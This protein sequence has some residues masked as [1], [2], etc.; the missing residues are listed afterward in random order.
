MLAELWGR[1]RSRTPPWIIVPDVI[2]A[3]AAALLRERVSPRLAPFHIPNRGR[4]AFAD[5]GGEGELVAE[6]VQLCEHLAQTE[7]TLIGARLHRLRQGDYAL[8][9]DDVCTRVERG[10]HL[11][12]TLDFSAAEISCAEV[13]YGDGRESALVIP[14][15]PGSMALV[16]RE[17]LVR[18]TA[19]EVL[20]YDRYLTHPVGAREVF[21]LRV[22]LQPK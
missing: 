18:G 2:P 13:L 17:P 22:V 11:E 8:R 15:L 5:A 21:R 4:Y 6:V 10:R 16:E 9:W 12:A 14:H 3:E 7:L 19:D 1:Y 20:R